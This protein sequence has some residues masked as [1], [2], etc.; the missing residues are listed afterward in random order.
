MIDDNAKILF[1]RPDGV[2]GYLTRGDIRALMGIPTPDVPAPHEPLYPDVRVS[3][4][5]LIECPNM[6]AAIA[7]VRRTLCNEVNA[8][9]ARD[10]AEAAEEITWSVPGPVLGLIRR[11]VTVV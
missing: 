4:A 7:L 2:T 3:A 6:T 1:T 10:F 11:W 8:E 9:V 5:E